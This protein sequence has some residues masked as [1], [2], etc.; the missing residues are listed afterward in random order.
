MFVDQVDLLVLGT[1]TPDTSLPSTACM[2]QER[3]G[4]NAPAMDVQQHARALHMHL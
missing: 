1:F 2:V 4:I 3:L